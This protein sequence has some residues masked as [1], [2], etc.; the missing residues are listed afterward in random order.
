[1]K[2]DEILEKELNYLLF[3]V[4]KKNNEFIQDNQEYIF[5]VI[6]LITNPNFKIEIAKLRE[7]YHIPLSY[8]KDDENFYKWLFAQRP[9]APYYGSKEI[10]D[11]CLLCRVNPKVYGDF[12]FGYLYFGDVMPYKPYDDI[13]INA[14]DEFRFKSKLEALTLD[15]N[16]IPR[17]DLERGYIRFYKDSTI[18]GILNFINANR[19]KIREIQKGLKPYPYTRTKKY[20]NFKR[21]IQVYILHLLK[22]NKA[23]ILKQLYLENIPD[24]N[25]DKKLDEV[26]QIE[27]TKV[28]EIIEDIEERLKTFSK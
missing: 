3:F 5:T 13:S 6:Y 12:V 28:Y 10:T 21:D 8:G 24:N 27:D 11:I 20:K 1:M 14:K 4:Q 2:I 9:F 16:T 23:D 25:T 26:Y 15:Y 18:E 17:E 19:D 7:K 22:K